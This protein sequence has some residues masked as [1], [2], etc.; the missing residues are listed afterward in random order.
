MSDATAFV[1]AGGQS[2]RMGCDKALL[3]CSGETLL[4]RALATA[5]QACGRALICGSRVLYGD[6]GEVVEDIVPGCGPLG[7]IH[8]ALHA[9]QSDLNF[10]LSVDMPLMQAAFLRWLLAE[11]HSGEQMITAPEALSRWQPLCAVY[12]RHVVG[13]VD[14]AIAKHDYKVTR[15]FRRTATRVVAE[16]EIRAAGFGPGIFTNVNTPEEYESLQRENSTGMLCGEKPA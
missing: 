4:Q 16:N 5:R 11:A 6:F 15:L 12:K 13:L 10:M 8:A 7:G 3:Q 1:L 9:T 2:S 14:E